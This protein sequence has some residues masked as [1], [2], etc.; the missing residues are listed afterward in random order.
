MTR[1]IIQVHVLLYRLYPDVAVILYLFIFICYVF[2]FTVS[3]ELF[4]PLSLTLD[5]ILS[6]QVTCVLTYYV[7]TSTVFTLSKLAFKP[8]NYYIIII[9][10]L[11]FL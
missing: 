5:I 3:E 4:Y 9:Y 1:I 2:K 10:F 7:A 11:S 6:L 8:L